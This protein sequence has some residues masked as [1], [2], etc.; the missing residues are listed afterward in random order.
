MMI[1]HEV[2]SPC[3]GELGDSRPEKKRIS[4]AGP[5]TTSR[6]RPVVV[7]SLVFG[8]AWLLLAPASQMA[9]GQSVS[10][11]KLPAPAEPIHGSLVICGGAALPPEVIQRFI[12]LADGPN[13]RL[14][15]IPT[16]SGVA[17]IPDELEPRIAI[18]RQQQV[19]ELTFLH[20]RSPDIANEAEFCAPLARAT[21]VWFIGGVQS[22]ITDAY[23]GTQAEQE[24]HGVLRRGGVIGGTSAGAAV[25][26]QV[27]IRRGIPGGADLGR[28]FGFFP[29]AVIDQ[30]FLKRNRTPRLMSVL[31]DHPGHFGLGIDEET[32]VVVQD[33]ML[34]VIGNSQAVVCH[35]ATAGHSEE[36]V[37]LK[38]GDEAD[39]VSISDRAVARAKTS[40][41]QVAD[42]SNTTSSPTEARPE[43]PSEST[44][45]AS[46]MK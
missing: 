36:T 24:F 39:F 35:P 41:I 33:N 26:T 4:P 7:R 43:V 21:G 30:H 28:G 19:Q 6:R 20:T 1:G 14:V 8:A 45:S 15:V 23:L 13:A 9:Y 18:W 5:A 42:K 44:T 11:A 38:S 29:N 3:E 46:A 16:A 17:E 27:M 31:L 25:M 37:F 34:S 32:A 22:R 10:A 12:A 2:R 40:A